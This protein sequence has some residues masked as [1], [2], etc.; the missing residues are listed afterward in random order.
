VQAVRQAL[1]YLLVSRGLPA[2]RSSARDNEVHELQGD[3]PDERLDPWV[4]G[5]SGWPRGP[6]LVPDPYSL[7]CERKRN[8]C[9]LTETGNAAVS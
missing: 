7:S 8:N 2:L 9:R 5:S 6:P 4:R 1:R 3:A